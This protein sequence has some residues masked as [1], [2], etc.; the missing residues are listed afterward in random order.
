[1]ARQKR[2]DD[3]QEH[4]DSNPLTEPG[5]TG[6][7]Q[8]YNEEPPPSQDLNPDVVTSTSVLPPTAEQ[9]PTEP[10]RRGPKPTPRR[11]RR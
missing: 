2:D 4:T 3:E 10:R 7:P 1:M 9:L 5:Q 11:G 6:F 8:E